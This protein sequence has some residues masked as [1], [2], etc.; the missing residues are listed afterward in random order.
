MEATYTQPNINIMEFDNFAL[1]LLVVF[2]AISLTLVRVVK[3][4]K[5]CYD[6]CALIK[7]DIMVTDVGD[8]RKALE[9]FLKIEE[10]HKMAFEK[11]T[12]KKVYTAYNMWLAKFK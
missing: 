5:R 12:H 2:I 3:Q 9:I 11:N 4:A 1:F 8:H 10:A 6:A 7:D